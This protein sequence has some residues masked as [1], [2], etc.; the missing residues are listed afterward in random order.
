M[1]LQSS[2]KFNRKL[3]REESKLLSGCLLLS[4]HRGVPH[5]VEQDF[6]PSLFIMTLVV[7]RVWPTGQLLSSETLV[8]QR[9]TKI[10]LK[11]HF[12]EIYWFRYKDS[13]EFTVTRGLGI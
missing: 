6:C 2:D 12:M 4:A 5:G 13:L 1:R 10:P 11:C 9:K 8:L 3:N 7:E